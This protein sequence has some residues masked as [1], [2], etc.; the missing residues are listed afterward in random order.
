MRSKKAE[1][2]PE[3]LSAV[4]LTHTYAYIQFR[5]I[6]TNVYRLYYVVT[7]EQCLGDSTARFR[8]VE[9]TVHSKHNT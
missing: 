7:L 9:V 8:R 5:S 1:T 3:E 2:T 6:A 4:V